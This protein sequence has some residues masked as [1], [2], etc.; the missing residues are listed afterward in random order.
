[1]LLCVVL[2][3]G[4]W[5]EVATSFIDVERI[6]QGT[7]ARSRGKAPTIYGRY[8]SGA[9]KQSVNASSFDSDQRRNPFPNMYHKLIQK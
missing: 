3:C 9:E 2:C 7:G 8:N 5:S 4:E 1:M 6:K